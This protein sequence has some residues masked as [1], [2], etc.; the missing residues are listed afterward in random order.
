MYERRHKYGGTSSPP[1]SD[2]RF[3][4][5][6]LEMH[7]FQPTNTQL[8]FYPISRY[9]HNSLPPHPIEELNS[10][11]GQWNTNGVKHIM[12]RLR[13][14]P[15]RRKKASIIFDGSQR[16]IQEMN[17]NIGSNI[18]LVD[19]LIE[20]GQVIKMRLQKLKSKTDHKG[21]SKAPSTNTK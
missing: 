2:Y 18:P 17:N 16:M 14:K 15:E 9:N 10:H 1:N 20:K 7:K 21:L 8:E 13:A 5:S 12:E 4:G 19:K 3:A 6:Q 11:E